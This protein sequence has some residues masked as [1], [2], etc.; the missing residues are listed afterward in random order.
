MEQ[1]QQLGQEGF[2]FRPTDSEGLMFLLRFVVGQEMHDSGFTTT[3]V[4]V[5]GK[6]EPWE[7]YDNGVPCG[8][9][10]D[11]TSYRYFITK[12]KRKNKGTWKQDNKG[13]PVHYINMGNASS[14]VNI[15][16]KTNLSYKN[17]VFYPED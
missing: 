2:R 10:E 8:D 15:G 7:I 1:I 5:Y 11:S 3:N 4:D 17:K 16:S 9:D 14:V 6:Q 13:K 12:L